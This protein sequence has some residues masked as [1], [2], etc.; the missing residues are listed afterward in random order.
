MRLHPKC[1]YCKADWSSVSSGGLLTSLYPMLRK[2]GVR[3]GSERLS[4]T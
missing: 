3:L 2:D 4:D 1:F